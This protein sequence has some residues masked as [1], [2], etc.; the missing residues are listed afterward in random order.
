M[1]FQMTRFSVSSSKRL[2]PFCRPDRQLSHLVIKR[3]E[4]GV[5]VIDRVYGEV[6]ADLVPS[7]YFFDIFCVCKEDKDLEQSVLCNLN[8][9]F[10]C[11]WS[12]EFRVYVDIDGFSPACETEP[13]TAKCKKICLEISS[14]V[15]AE[16]DVIEAINTA[17]ESGG[18]ANGS[19][20]LKKP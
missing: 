15:V 20:I 11:V 3:H 10:G 13:G 6:I 16:W 17:V 12:V 2:A 8:P 14:E 18:D 1:Q 19:A 5:H 4:R 9:Y 7:L